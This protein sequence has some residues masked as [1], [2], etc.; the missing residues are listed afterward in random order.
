MVLSSIGGEIG[1]F[2][3]QLCLWIQYLT[4]PQIVCGRIQQMLLAC[5]SSLYRNWVSLDLQ[6]GLN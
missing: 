3:I 2:S 6:N 5:H 4:L 1:E